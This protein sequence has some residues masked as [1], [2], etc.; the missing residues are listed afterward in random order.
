MASRI[1]QTQGRK[2]AGGQNNWIITFA[3]LMTLLLTFFILLLS[4]SEIDAER[5]RLMVRS[6]YE[7]FG[8]Q[9]V[10]DELV[11]GSPITLVESEKVPAP[12]P[13]PDAQPE[14]VPQQGQPAQPAEPSL[15]TEPRTPD[16]TSEVDQD[17]ER[18]ASELIQQF[19][20]EVAQEEMSVTY[21]QHKVVV[22]FSE[23]A[24]FP[25]G[26]AS[27]KSAMEPLLEEMVD[28]LARCEGQIVVAGH[29]DDR[30]IVSSRFRSNWDLSAARAVSVVHELVL[31]RQIDADRVSA[32]GH[33]E[34][35]PL[36]PNDSPE[37][38]ARNRR[39]EILMYEPECQGL[40]QQAAESETLITP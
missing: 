34:T 27:L 20:E 26:S 32:A 39:V 21:D 23:E 7:A 29:T 17:I 2:K 6:M 36:V 14:A 5:Y 33:A 4:F 9:T 18:M 8:G 10:D 3:D 40:E 16:D 28:I 12:E 37:N 25:S 24:S 35:Q 19:S 13:S 38:R 11:G 31:N 30:P 15:I 1:L 22:R